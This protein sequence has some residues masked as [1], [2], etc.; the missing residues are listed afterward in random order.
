MQT[1]TDTIFEFNS[2]VNGQP[3]YHHQLLH[4]S[5]VSVYLTISALLP[6]GLIGIQMHYHPIY[7][8]TTQEQIP[9]KDPELNF[10]QQPKAQTH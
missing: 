8:V 3:H 1:I 5:F 4:K 7:P 6:V 10:L 2:N 9:A